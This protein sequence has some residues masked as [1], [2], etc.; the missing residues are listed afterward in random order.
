[1]QIA[2]LEKVVGARVFERGSGRRGVCLTPIGKVLIQHVDALLEVVAAG[3][4]DVRRA[5]AGEDTPPLRLGTFQSLS[6]RV[7]PRMLTRF[8]AR[9][10][11]VEVRLSE[12]GDDREHWA[13]MERAELDLAFTLL[14][15]D[16][17]AL[18]LVEVLR[19]RHALVVP[20]DHWAAD[21][22]D[23]LAVGAGEPLRL[24]TYRSRPG[25]HLASQLRALGVRVRVVQRSDDNRTIQGLVAA[26]AGVAV[27]PWLGIE[28]A[29][30]AVRFLSLDGMLQPRVVALAWPSG[31]LSAAGQVMVDAAIEACHAVEEDGLVVGPPVLGRAGRVPLRHGS[32]AGR[33]D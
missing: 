10:P 16:T 18:E 15:V 27:M 6:Q 23:L 29:D 20:V 7:I 2:A 24:L 30:P 5:L 11:G 19:V 32:S 13:A 26:G 22:R 33:R 9:V 31:R 25:D 12:A 1:M 17:A 8:H 28:R 4:L 3:E 14:P 21:A